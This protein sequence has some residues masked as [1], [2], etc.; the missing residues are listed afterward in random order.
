M[1]KKKRVNEKVQIFKISLFDG[2]FPETTSKVTIKKS[3]KTKK[4]RNVELE[5]HNTQMDLVQ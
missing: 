5:L 4:K 2:S 3:R 1:T